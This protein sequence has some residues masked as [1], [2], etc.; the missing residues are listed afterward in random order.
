MLNVLLAFIIALFTSMKFSHPIAQLAKVLKNFDPNDEM[1]LPRVKV[2]EV[3]E[4][5][6]SIEELSR[7]LSSGI[8]TLPGHPCA[9][10]ANRRH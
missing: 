10:Y 6:S 7:N 2:L 3:D 9:G 4:L 5:A 1:H 8:Q